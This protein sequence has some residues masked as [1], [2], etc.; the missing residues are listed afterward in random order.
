M[1]AVLT[2]RF[3]DALGFAFDLH[4]QQRRAGS[5]VPYFAHL[6]GVSSLAIENGADEDE[7]IGALLHDAAEDQGGRPTL[8]AIA[9]RF[10]ARVAQIVEGCTD[11]LDDGQGPKPKWRPRKEAYVAHLPAAPPSVQLVSAC[12]KLYNARAILADLRE[13]GDVVWTRF[14]GK[15]DGVLWYY[16]ALADAFTVR[17]PVVEELRRVVAELE[18]VASSP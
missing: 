8:A 3:R 4:R 17:K 11:W 1:S 13:V 12:D 18:R 15:R 6:I 14:A 10:G 7:A 5:D 9:A 2:D 16:R